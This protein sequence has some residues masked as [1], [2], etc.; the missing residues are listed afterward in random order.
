LDE[1]VEIGDLGGDRLGAMAEFGGHQ[2]GG[3][4]ELV[5]NRPD[6]AAFRFL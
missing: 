2:L 4:G 5:A 1:F 3:K 6:A